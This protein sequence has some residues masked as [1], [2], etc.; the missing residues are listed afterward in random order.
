MKK[1]PYALLFALIVLSIIFGSGKCFG[2]DSTSKK[3][4]NFPHQKN[5]L[6]VES[7]QTNSWLPP[8]RGYFKVH[9]RIWVVTR[10]NSAQERGH[11]QFISDTS[12][13]LNGK[14]IKLKDIVI[15]KKVKGGEISVAGGSLTVIGLIFSINSMANFPDIENTGSF[16]GSVM[17]TLVAGI[18]TL[19][20]VIQVGSA[21]RYQMEDGWRFY[22][23]PDVFENPMMRFPDKS[24][25][26]RGNTPFVPNK[27]M[28]MPGPFPGKK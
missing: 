28:K 15:I 26:L 11:I 9:Q 18:F 17:G 10:S 13:F 3:F 14:E 8:K 20:G 1:L 27:G 4:H 21:H 22:V 19:V 6:I 2:Q 5:I 24:D 16:V 7:T 12:L 25:T 23:K